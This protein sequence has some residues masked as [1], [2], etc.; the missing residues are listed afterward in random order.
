M[1]RFYGVFFLFN[2]DCYLYLHKSV[3]LSSNM[4]C[5]YDV[6][7]INCKYVNFNMFNCIVCIILF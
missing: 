4:V 3:S 5:K 6:N 2:S 7:H 1:H